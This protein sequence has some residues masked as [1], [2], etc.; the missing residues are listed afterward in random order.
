ML[1]GLGDTRA[2]MII[3]GVGYWLIGLPLGVVLAFAGGLAGSGVW[4]GL[5]AGLA[6]VAVMLGVRWTLRD[7][8]GLTPPHPDA[9]D[10]GSVATGVPAA[11]AVKKPS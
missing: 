6:A 10:V 4:I 9:R 8:L 11:V 1:R 2:P 3:C 7:G 5:S